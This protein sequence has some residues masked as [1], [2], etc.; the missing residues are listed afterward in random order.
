MYSGAVVGRATVTNVLIVPGSNTLASEFHYGPQPDTNSGLVTA[1]LEDSP[2]IT[3]WSG[4]S[5]NNIP[6]TVM[7]DSQSTP[8]GS[9]LPALEGVTLQASFPGFG[10]LLVSYID[11]F[12]DFAVAFCQG[13]TS[14]EVTVSSPCHLHRRRVD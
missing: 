8:Y 5:T 9:L 13:Y 14:I 6:I 1:Y 12:V 3:S 10:A 2:T 11:I 4:A 7:G